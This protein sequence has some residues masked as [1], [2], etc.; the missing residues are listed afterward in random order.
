MQLLEELE[1][2]LDG[3]DKNELDDKS[4][5]WETSEGAEFGKAKLEEIRALLK[6]ELAKDKCQVNAP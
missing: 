3:I 2:I 6:E 1:K 5:W 4:G